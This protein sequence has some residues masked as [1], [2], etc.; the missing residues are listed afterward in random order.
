MLSIHSFHKQEYQLLHY[1]LS[2]ARIFFRA[3]LTAAEEDEQKETQGM[4]SRS[5]IFDSIVTIITPAADG[6]NKPEGENNENGGQ[7]PPP[8]PSDPGIH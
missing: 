6:G 7:P 1:S 5:S 8:L 3:D 4:L 2:S